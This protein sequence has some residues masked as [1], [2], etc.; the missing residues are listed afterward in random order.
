[1]TGDT[2][3][4]SPAANLQSLQAGAARLILSGTD[5]IEHP[6][7][8][9]SPVRPSLGEEYRTEKLVDLC[10][11][12]SVFCINHQGRTLFPLYAFDRE[13]RPLPVIGEVVKLLGGRTGWQLAAW[14]ESTSS[15]LD[16][17]R[18]REVLQSSPERVLVAAKVHAAG[19]LH[20]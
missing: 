3:E 1:M 13:G 9:E 10:D 6:G 16:G 15:V 19:P 18:P 7:E 11:S 17:Q 2:P 8:H 14:F 20:G 4:N 12:P 5:W